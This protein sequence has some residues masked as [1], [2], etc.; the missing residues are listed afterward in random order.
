MDKSKMKALQ[1]KK[2]TTRIRNTLI[3]KKIMIMLESIKKKK[4]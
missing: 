1:D 2:K 4:K 3:K